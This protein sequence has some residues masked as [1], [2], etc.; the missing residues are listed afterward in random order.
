MR[1]W[2]RPQVPDLTDLR[3]RGFYGVVSE[4]IVGVVCGDSTNVDFFMS[5]ML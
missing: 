1:W 4:V 2:W 3:D 5:L